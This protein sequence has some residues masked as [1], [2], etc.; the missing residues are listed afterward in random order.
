MEAQSEMI[1]ITVVIAGRPY[2]LKINSNDEPVIRRLV[3]EVNDKVKQFQLTYKD[4]DKQDCLSMSLLTYA[5]DLHKSKSKTASTPSA[6]QLSDSLQEID[7][8]LDA[9]LED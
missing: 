2:P 9:L 8:L 6:N 1:R 4:R 3:K 7:T 5:L